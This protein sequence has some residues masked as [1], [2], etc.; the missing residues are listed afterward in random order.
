MFNRVVQQYMQ[1][2]IT[3]EI[4]WEK[5]RRKTQLVHTLAILKNAGRKIA[6]EDFVA[7]NT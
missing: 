6:M 2:L 5:V 4:L 7:M 3:F 1:P